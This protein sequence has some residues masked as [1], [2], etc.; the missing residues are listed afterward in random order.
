[1]TTF[2]L[3]TH[4]A[5]PVKTHLVITLIVHRSA[6]IGLK[7]GHQ[8]FTPQHPYL[9]V[10]AYRAAGITAG[11]PSCT[12][13]ADTKTAT[14]LRCQDVYWGWKW[15]LWTFI[16]NSTIFPTVNEPKEKLLKLRHEI[17]NHPVHTHV[18]VAVQWL[19][20]T[21]PLRTVTH[22]KR[23][24]LGYKRVQLPLEKISYILVY[25]VWL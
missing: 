13:S 12:F 24:C 11:S 14:R 5:M 7:N 18:Y 3:K 9:S 17:M 23:H 6:F 25:K 10:A 19:T 1:M 22:I 21:R 8:I 15:S 2:K 16:V 4:P 20:V